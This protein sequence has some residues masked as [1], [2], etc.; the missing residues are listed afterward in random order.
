[1]SKTKAA[2]LTRYEIMFIVP[3]KYTEVE[4][5][6]I[7][8]RVEKMIMDGN[9]QIVSGE[10]WGKKKMA[11]EIKHNAYG[12][13]QLYQFDF[14][15]ESLIKLNNDLRLSTE[16][17][18]HQILKIKVKSEEQLAKEQAARDR[19]IAK[20]EEAKEAATK[21]IKK[22]TPHKKKA[23]D[24]TELKDLDKKLDGIIENTKDLV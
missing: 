14:P 11:Y 13:Y 22:A 12:Y 24:K 18:R 8:G 23:E 17:L 4:A 5:K 9:G 19:L 20:E 15:G 10:Y 6:T 16:I 1:M 3:N 7:I 21:F 2:G